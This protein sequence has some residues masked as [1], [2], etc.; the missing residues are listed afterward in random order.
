MPDFDKSIKESNLAIKKN[1]VN[2]LMTCTVVEFIDKLVINISLDGEMDISYDLQIPV[3]DDLKKPL[4]QFNNDYEEDEVGIEDEDNTMINN[5]TIVP[6]LLIGAGN[7]MKTQVLASQIGFIL[8]QHSS[9]NVIL[10]ISGKF[11]GNNPYD[12]TYKKEDYTSVQQIV[13]LVSDTL[14]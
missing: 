2:H 6:I 4:R 10:N 9:K 13:Q 14:V 7:N 5:S 3:L 11:F 1:G 8:S 12:D